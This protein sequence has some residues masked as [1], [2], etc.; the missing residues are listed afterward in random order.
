M[1]NLIIRIVNFYKEI[2]NIKQKIRVM[3]RSKRVRENELKVIRESARCPK[4]PN[5]CERVASPD[6]G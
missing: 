4:P 3:S 6:V 1:K 2:I 5:V